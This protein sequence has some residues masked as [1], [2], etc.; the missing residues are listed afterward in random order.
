MVHDEMSGEELSGVEL[1]ALYGDEKKFMATTP[2]SAFAMVT[3]RKLYTLPAT[4]KGS[5]L[6]FRA[7][8]RQ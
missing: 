4:A 7:S 3:A 2:A 8:Q 6:S 1:L 5:G